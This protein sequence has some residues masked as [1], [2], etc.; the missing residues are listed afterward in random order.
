[1]ALNVLV[2]L[3][4]TYLVESISNI[5]DDT[6]TLN[7]SLAAQ[8]VPWSDVGGSYELDF[9]HA[10]PIRQPQ[11]L[12]GRSWW[13]NAKNAGNDALNTTEGNL[14]ETKNASFLLSAG[15]QNKRTTIYTDPG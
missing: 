13:D 12:Q 11:Q 8:A 14:D 15:Q 10:I 5:T 2:S 3:V 4:D 9:G 7:L 6:A 1:M